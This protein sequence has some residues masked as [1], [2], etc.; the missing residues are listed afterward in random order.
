MGRRW[1]CA[2]GKGDVT[3]TRL[4]HQKG[5]NPQRIGSPVLVGEHAY[6]VNDLGNAQCLEVKTGKD[7]W[8]KQRVGSAWGSMVHAA[9]RLYVCNNAG[10]TLVLAANPK[11]ELLARNSL[12]E[13]VRSSLAVVDDEILIRTDKHLWCIAAGKR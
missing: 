3:E 6:Q 2:G 1:R 10:D 11:Y 13:Q 5:R 4:W 9:G 8:D 12:G 7:L